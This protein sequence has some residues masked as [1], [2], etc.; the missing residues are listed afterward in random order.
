MTDLQPAPPRLTR[1]EM[2]GF[3]SF[4]T[5]T[6][7]V[8]DA[9]LTAIIGPNG[10]GKSNISDGLRWVL[11]EQ[12]HSLLRSK[13]TEDVIFAGGHGRAPAGL[14]EV[15]VTFDNSTGWLPIDFAEVTIT[16]RAYRSG[17]NQFLINGRRVRLKDIHHLTASLG[18]SYTVVGQG[19]V[20]AA[21]S[22]RAEERRGLFEHA[23]DLTGLRMKTAEAERNLNEAEANTA[24]M[25]DLLAELE[26]R[27]R[28]LER[29]AK[30]AREWQNVHDRLQY[31]QK[32]HF[33]ILLAG[34]LATLQEAEAASNTDAASVSAIRSEIDRLSHDLAAARATAEQ[35]RSALEH[36]AV[37]LQSVA[38]QERRV[39]H[40]RELAAERLAA[41]T[42][43]QE[44]MADTHHGLDEQ[45]AD[46]ARQTAEVEASIAQLDGQLADLRSAIEHLQAAVSRGRDARGARERQAANLATGASD[47]ERRLSDVERRRALLEQQRERD[48]SDRERA[49]QA[50]DERADRIAGLTA[51]LD[52][53]AEAERAGVSECE[54]LSQSLTALLAELERSQL[55]ERTVR[56]ELESINH[57]INETSARLEALERIQASGAGLFAG[58]QEVLAAAKRGQLAGVRGTIAELIVLPA[59]FDTAIEVALGGHLQDIVVERWRDAEAAIE[60]LKRAKRGRA[61]FQPIETVKAR[62][63][64]APASVLGA[65][66]VHGVA[67][68]LVSVSDELRPIVSALLGRT[69][70]VDD[71]QVTRR[72]LA[73]LPMGWNVVTLTGEIARTGGSVTGGAAVRES[74]MLGR[75]RE[76]R[77]LPVALDRLAQ[78]RGRL[79]V[80][81][82]AAQTA[83]QELT[84]ERRRIESERTSLEATQRERANQRGRLESWLRDL[85]R[86]HETAGQRTLALTQSAEN[87]HEALLA[88]ERE[89]A[90]LQR[91]LEQAR[92]A[93][94]A[95]M[96]DLASGGSD[97]DVAEEE[98]AAS[99]QRYAALEERLR[100]ERQR[101]TSL[102]AQRSALTDE[103]RV[104]AER[105]AE[106]DGQVL[107]MTS[108]RD[109]LT[110]EAE[111]L[112]AQRIELE[113]ERPPLAEAAK[114]A[115]R[116]LQDLQQQLDDTRQRLLDAERAHGVRELGV[117]RIRG[118]LTGIRQRITDELDLPDPDRLLDHVVEN[119]EEFA[120]AER[121]IARLKERLRRVGYIGEEAVEEFE[122]ESERHAFL[123]AQLDDVQGAATALRTLLDDL[124]ETMRQRFDETFQKVSVAFAETFATLFGGGSARLIM[125]AGENGDGAGIDIVAQP[126]GKRL[127]SLAL[128]SGGERALTAAALLFAILQVNPTPFCLLDEVDA[129][130]DEANIVRFRE[131][132]L[133]L[134][135]E[136]QAIIITHNRGTIEVADS[137]YGVSMRE[138]GV[139]QVLSLRMSDAIAAS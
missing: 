46:V 74:G 91:D 104:R 26:P 138:D 54:R 53:I 120:D 62:Q 102:Q 130:L 64:V 36:H 88:L 137:I 110:R 39:V 82:E 73:D 77:D 66:G 42:R 124:R 101:L 43:R 17:E 112:T 132:L 9:G 107:A 34:A 121:E 23:A 44:D 52:A 109:R 3:K 1:L 97:L 51:D 41:L 49:A 10:S 7:F 25:L 31:L 15:A 56:A 47:I 95:V 57:S 81:R 135:R 83:V 4:A 99:R 127:Q 111:A 90:T 108:Q 72:V 128:L 129:A 115:E 75:E 76:L 37:H 38:E 24:R 11:G 19:L 78:E 27:L 32:G 116:A 61:T 33:R 2:Q 21:L 103:L 67:A 113:R 16:R 86:E 98:L 70:I 40:E 12:S 18:Q 35:T 65:A 45:S 134:A 114:D 96:A 79:E 58:V 92:A 85:T 48:R 59:T 93:R 105:A 68:D 29:A 13:K 94:E 139:S 50:S 117:E 80:E 20:D 69:L 106:L 89:E 119:E 71:L 84:E 22:Q 126:P 118:E 30:Q 5:R 63:A 100:S 125:V 131:Q 6:V 122:R 55:A 60:H 136:S 28:T 87:V 8:F 133:A 123:R 14:A